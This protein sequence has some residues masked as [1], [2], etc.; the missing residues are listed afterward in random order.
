PHRRPHPRAASDPA[1]LACEVRPGAR[2]HS[3][4]R[5]GRD[6]Q[7][8]SYLSPHLMLL[9]P[10]LFWTSVGLWQPQPEKPAPVGRF[11]VIK[12]PGDLDND[13][14]AASIT[15]ELESAKGSSLIILELDGNKA[16]PDLVAG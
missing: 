12:A 4:L 7:E 16:R 5:A 11:V 2:A 13:R 8:S 6:G 15:S 10:L 14:F 3:L 9:V 1:R